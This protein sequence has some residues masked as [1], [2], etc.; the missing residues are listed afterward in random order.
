MT[1]VLDA[2]ALVA[3]ER[4][5]PDLT[6]WV[7]DEL[8]CGRTPLTHGGI[9]GQVWRGGRGRQSALAPLLKALDVA[10]LDDALG[11]RSGSLLAV[12]GSSDVLDAA[13]VLLARRG[14]SLVTSDPRDL[15]ELATAAGLQVDIVPV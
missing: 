14:D 7:K 10:P 9:V 5:D 4:R 6:A 3:L 11:R 2:G 13:I 15:D 8:R 12:T 1:L